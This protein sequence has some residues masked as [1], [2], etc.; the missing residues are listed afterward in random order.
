MQSQGVSELTF[1]FML[2]AGSAVLIV[3]AVA[4]VF[5]GRIPR[6]NPRVLNWWGV[7]VG[8]TNVAL[9]IA[10]L[11]EKGQTWPSILLLLV[12]MWTLI[13]YVPRLWSHRTNRR[14]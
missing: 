7:L 13:F 10:W 4:L 2:A 5:V 6:L 9:A 1:A 3:G 11:V 12:G 14:A 8:V